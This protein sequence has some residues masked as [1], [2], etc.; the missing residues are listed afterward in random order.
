MIIKSI[1]D[2][3]SDIK[4]LQELI[5]HP[6]ASAEVKRSIEKEIRN[7]RAGLKGELE[8]AYEIDFHY[9]ASKNWMVIHDLRI[10]CE[11][12]VAQID[13]LV[14]NRFLEIWVCESKHF[15]EGIAIN[16]HGECSAFYGNKPYGVSSPIEQNKKHIAVLESAFKAK[17]IDLPRRIG[18][19]ISPSMNS[20]ILVSNR[21]RI[22]RPKNKIAG[23][24]SIIKNEQ[25]KGRI[26]KAIDSDNNPLLMAKLVGPGTLEDFARKLVGLHKPIQFDWHAKFGLSKQSHEVKPIPPTLGNIANLDSA[27]EKAQNNS[28]NFIPRVGAQCPKCG[29]EKL[30]RKTIARGDGTET[31]FLACNG[32]P[33]TCKAIFPLVALVQEPPEPTYQSRIETN[34]DGGLVEGVPCPKCGNGKLVKRAGKGGRPDFLGCSS[35][36]KTKCRFTQ[37]IIS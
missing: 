27:P 6:D 7:I 33:K 17:M 32:Y 1:D 15:A 14:I 34:L 35:F 18:F 31:D 4:I 5:S 26:D 3:E 36:A 30:I 28:N 21:A 10:E 37:T 16:E 9:Q 13:H 11:G 25:I 12:R 23:L 2:K 29:Q 20:L 19:T 8:S 22:S 24:D